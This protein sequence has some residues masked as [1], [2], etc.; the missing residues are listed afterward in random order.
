MAERVGIVKK[1]WRSMLNLYYRLEKECMTD[2]KKLEKVKRILSFF[3]IDNSKIVLDNIGGKGYGDNPKYIAEELLKD[4]E[5]YKIIWL[6]N[7]DDLFFPAGITAVKKQ[8]LRAYYEVA[9]AKVWVTNV[10]FRKLAKKRCNQ[11]LLQTWHAG[12]AM[13]KIEGD[14]EDKLT[15]S[16]VQTAKTDGKECDG[17]LIDGK[18]NEDI[19]QRA[20][21]LNPNCEFLRFGSPRTDILLNEKDNR[22]LI[23]SVR[24][25]LGISRSS[26]VVLYAPTFRDDYSIDAYIEDYNSLYKVLEARFPEVTIAVRFHPNMANKMGGIELQDYPFMVNATL[27]PDS[28]E[29]VIASDCLI[30]DYSSIAFDFAMLNKPVFLYQAD[31]EAYIQERGVYPL[32]YDMPFAKNRT[33]EELLQEISSFS[34]E[35]MEKRIQLFYSKYPNFNTGCAAKKT[36]TWLKRRGLK[37]KA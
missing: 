28:Q 25:K 31:Q 10:R 16:Y 23:D 12:Q 19:F 32:F 27:Y 26:F 17:I 36:V 37:A 5:K 21:W 7:K 2:Q 13:K 8:S 22:E 14:A 35:E 15:V 6:T 24:E 1:I 4:S 18:Q 9:T 11:I 30:T 20:F 3:P 33:F 29:L 34:Q